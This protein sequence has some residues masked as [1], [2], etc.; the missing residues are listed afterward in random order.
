LKCGVAEAIV[1][2]APIGVGQYLVRLVEFLEPLL[3]FF[4]A[5]VA[6]RMKLDR[7]AAVRLLQFVFG[8]PAAYAQNLVVVA[9]SR[10]G[11]L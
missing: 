6:I 4:V 1:L 11:H 7:Q 10:G 3:G 8:S 5:G 9:F 2:R